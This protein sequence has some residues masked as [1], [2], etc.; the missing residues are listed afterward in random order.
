[1]A[2]YL[3]KVL[4][5][6]NITADPELKDVGTSKVCNFTLAINRVYYSKGDGENSV[7]KEETLFIRVAAWNRLAEQIVNYLKK[8]ANIFVEGRLT[9]KQWTQD[10]GTTKTFLDVTAEKVSFITSRGRSAE[11]DSNYNSTGGYEKH[12]IETD[13]EKKIT[14]DEKEKDEEDTTDLWTNE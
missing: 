10:D 8:G 7:K 2:F 14:S 13:T 4:F 11:T 9:S 12:S 3:N 6:G 5:A 1:M